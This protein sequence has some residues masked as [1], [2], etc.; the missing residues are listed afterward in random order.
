[1]VKGRREIVELL[2]QKGAHVEAR[3]PG[4][5]TGDGVVPRVKRQY[6]ISSAAEYDLLRIGHHNIGWQQD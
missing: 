2:L 3:F 4:I 6:L 1:V 5:L